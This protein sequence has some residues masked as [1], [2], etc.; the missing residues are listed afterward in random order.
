MQ[1]PDRGGLDSRGHWPTQ[2]LSVLPRMGKRRSGSFP[3]NLSF[4]L[5]EDRQQSR[6][7]STGWRGRTQS[8]S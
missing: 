4:K 6:N 7:G 8:L 1:F 2:P 5:G 3:Q